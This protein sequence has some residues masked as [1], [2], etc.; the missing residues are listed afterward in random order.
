M[1]YEPLK[2]KQ[3]VNNIQQM[4]K[5]FRQENLQTEMNVKHAKLDH[6]QNE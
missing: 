4:N 6:N 3:Q 5:H 1:T 2:N